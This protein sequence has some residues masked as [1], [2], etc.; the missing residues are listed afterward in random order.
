MGYLKLAVVSSV[1]LWLCS[2]SNPA[3]AMATEEIG[4]VSKNGGRIS[5]QPGWPAHFVEIAKHD[6]RVYS[7]WTNGS[8]DMYFEANQTQL[9]ELIDRFAGTRMRDHEIWIKVGTPVVLTFKK[10]KISYNIHVQ[11]L[12]E[13]ARAVAQ[14][15]GDV[16]PTKTYDPV[17]TIT[18][19]PETAIEVL[20]QLKI[21][22]HFIVHNEV[23]GSTFKTRANK[24]KRHMRFAKVMFDENT[25]ATVYGEEDSIVTFVTLWDKAFSEGIYLNRVDVRGVFATPLSDRELV[26]LTQGEL[27]ITLTVGDLTA[28]PKRDDPRLSPGKLVRSLDAANPVMVKR[29]N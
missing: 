23:P 3:S 22:D 15:Q 6:S 21:P 13:M 19:D 28:E 12:G 29:N 16:D 1:V 4:P 17:M 20:G 5:V 27:W 8:D 7:R 2:E 24:P 10:Q 14:M 9:G 25:P 18:L 26:R 11:N